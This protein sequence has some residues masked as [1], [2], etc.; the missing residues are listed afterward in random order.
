MAGTIPSGGR[1]DFSSQIK[2]LTTGF[3]QLDSGMRMQNAS[4]LIEGLTKD[5]VDLK[6]GLDTG[7]DALA[8]KATDGISQKCQQIARELSKLD[9]DGDGTA[10]IEGAG[11]AQSRE[12]GADDGTAASGSTGGKKEVE[13]WEGPQWD[14]ADFEGVDGMGAKGA[15]GKKTARPSGGGKGGGGVSGASGGGGAGGASG[16]S[17]ASGGQ[18][19]NPLSANASGGGGGTSAAGG[20]SESGAMGEFESGGMCFE[21]MIQSLMMKVV[22][23]LQREA[24]AIMKK[25][26]SMSSKSGAKEGGS[27]A[28][29]T[30][31]A[32][33][34]TGGPNAP[35][36]QP[37]GSGGAAGADSSG[38]TGPAA[39][40]VDDS[41]DLMMERLKVAM[42]KLSQCQQAMSNVINTMHENAMNP[43][44]NIKG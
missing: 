6:S 31:G 5:F 42:Q 34:N 32:A 28:D 37:S 22:K 29:G 26:E 17:G 3:R 11:G 35:A 13:K 7:N 36:G 40:N 39:G 38:G 8:Q 15:G 2:D 18:G 23:Q 21:D 43:I 12:V 19:T 9:I 41:R 33:P 25:L 10:D 4:K 16:A 14:E 30:G 24:A 27:T 1:S 20:D 44:R